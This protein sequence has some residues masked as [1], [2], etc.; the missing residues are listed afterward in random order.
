MD[1]FTMYSKEQNKTAGRRGYSGWK[2]E[3]V[4][5]IRPADYGR[6]LRERK[7]GWLYGFSRSFR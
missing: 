7:G 6:Y 1:I 5:I 3:K 4:D 2:F